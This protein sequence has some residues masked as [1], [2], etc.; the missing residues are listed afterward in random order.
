VRPPA[1][2]TVTADPIPCNLPPLPKPPHLGGVEQGDNVIVTRDSLAE[3]GRW[4]AGIYAWIDSAAKCLP[5][6]P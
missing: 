6:K 5:R 1:Q 2:I 4:V 3:M